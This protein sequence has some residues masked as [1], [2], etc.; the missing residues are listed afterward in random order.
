M[1]L[2]VIAM[3]HSVE[4]SGTPLKIEMECNYITWAADYNDDRP[5]PAGRRVVSHPTS[6]QIERF[7]ATAK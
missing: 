1:I 4:C 7:T 6:M 3:I 2:S 5:M